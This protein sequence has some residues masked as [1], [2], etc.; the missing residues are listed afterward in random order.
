MMW[1]TLCF[2][3]GVRHVWLPETNFWMSGKYMCMHTHIHAHFCTAR[4]CILNLCQAL[5]INRTC[6]RRGR[7]QVRQRLDS[8]D[9]SSSLESSPL[10]CAILSISWLICV[11]RFFMHKMKGIIMIPAFQDGCKDQM[12]PTMLRVL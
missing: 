9:L 1:L 10:R 11:L 7:R 3:R 4:I 5:S 6:E 8:E 12:T 2:L